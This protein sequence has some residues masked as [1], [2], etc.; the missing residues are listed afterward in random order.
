MLIIKEAPTPAIDKAWQQNAELCFRGGTI[1]R[2][3][4]ELERQAALLRKQWDSIGNCLRLWAAW[5][6]YLQREAQ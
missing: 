6:R 5:E 1:I 2:K 3:A 4:R